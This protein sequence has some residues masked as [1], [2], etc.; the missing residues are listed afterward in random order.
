VFSLL[1]KLLPQKEN[2]VAERNSIMLV[3]RACDATMYA[4]I[5]LLALGIL[6]KA[7][8]PLGTDDDILWK[9]DD[10]INRGG[11]L[12]LK[13]DCWQ[14]YE[15]FPELKYVTQNY[16]SGNVACDRMRTV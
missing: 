3:V 2:Q 1:S 11:L 7:E 16:F 5:L 4:F 9:G 13:E 10:L 6:A 8:N 15:Y 12:P 14:T